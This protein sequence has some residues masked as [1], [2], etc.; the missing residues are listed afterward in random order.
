MGHA[1]GLGLADTALLLAVGGPRPPAGYRRS[2]TILKRFA[3]DTGE[4]PL[5]AYATMAALAQPWLTPLP[6]LDGRGNWG[7]PGNDPPADAGYTECRLSPAGRAAVDAERGTGPPVPL[8]LVNGSTFRGGVRPPF[9]PAR[10]AAAVLAVATGGSPDEAARTVG[11]PAFPGGS[12][13]GFDT[14]DR[15]LDHLRRGWHAG[16]TFDSVLERTEDRGRPAL[17]VVVLPPYVNPDEVCTRVAELANAAQG[18]SP[19]RDLTDLTSMHTGLRLRF[20]PATDVSLDAAEE[21]LRRVP[22]IGLH[23]YVQLSAPLPDLLQRWVARHG[24]RAAGAG[25]AVLREL[26]DQ[27]P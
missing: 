24:K 18:R 16:L 7:S 5:D 23:L 17:D 22:G 20:I 21:F 10:V 25:A 1:T 27:R 2:A 14:D 9:D 26:A 13:M 6:L 19:I 4:D 8:G 3:A 15:G 12:T 11:L